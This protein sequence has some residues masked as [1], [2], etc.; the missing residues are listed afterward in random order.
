MKMRKNK[1]NL[2]QPIID[3]LVNIVNSAGYCIGREVE[4]KLLEFPKSPVTSFKTNSILLCDV[5]FR[6]ENYNVVKNGISKFELISVEYSSYKTFVITVTQELYA[7]LEL[8]NVIGENSDH[9]ILTNRYGQKS[10]VSDIRSKS[11]DFDGDIINILTLFPTLEYHDTDI[12]YRYYMNDITSIS[13]YNKSKLLKDFTTELKKKFDE[14]TRLEKEK[15]R[16]RYEAYGKQPK[17]KRALPF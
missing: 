7:L 1:M 16:W 6:N 5:I 2:S 12:A 11:S 3:T 14:N 10:V 15:K 8:E 9:P 4:V 17:G 13:K